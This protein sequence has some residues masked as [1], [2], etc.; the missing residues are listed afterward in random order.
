MRRTAHPTS[1]ATASP[2][3]EEVLGWL[4]GPGS[5]DPLLDLVPL[6][7]HIGTIDTL[8]RPVLHRLKI[9]ELLQLRAERIDAALLPLLLDAKLP[10]PHQLA[11]VAQGLIGLRADLGEAWLAIL[12]DA[13][14]EELHKVHRTPLQ[15]CLRG[16]DNLSRQLTASLLVSIPTPIGL[17]LNIQRFYHQ[18]GNSVD[19]TA[20]YPAE[21]SQIELRLKAMLALAAAQPEGLAPRELAFL[22]DYLVDHA[23]TVRLDPMP[24]DTPADWLW[25]GAN[26]D[27]QPVALGRRPPPPGEHLFFR[28]GSL[29]DLAG[30]HLKQLA[31]GT[32][33]D[34]LGLPRQ[35]AGSDYQNTLERARQCWLMPRRRSYNRQQREVRAQVCIHLGNLWAA[36]GGKSEALAQDNVLDPTTSEWGVLNEGPAGYA[37]VLL[38]GRVSGIVAGCAI[39]L[40]TGD[41]APWQICLVR[42][43]RSEHSDHLELGLEV[44]APSAEAVRIQTTNHRQQDSQVAALLLPA[45]PA[46]NRTEAILTARGAFNL[47]PFTLIQEKTGRLQITECAPERTLIETSSVEVFDFVRLNNQA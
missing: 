11:T 30:N 9:A 40:R 19:P 41:Q 35:L 18:A 23:V 25:I 27:Q 8:R 44:L 12:R 34:A 14:P 5:D 1:A 10:L 36:L 6:R 26:I 28:C 17:W 37:M 22:A 24:P 16:L 21:M 33:P 13:T 38:S 4:A 45:L 29:A 32:P 43:A 15:I 20:T 7:K 46:I 31:D 3:L 2:E 47:S 42:W 39:G